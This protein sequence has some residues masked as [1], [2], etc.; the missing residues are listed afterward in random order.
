MEEETKLT[1]TMEAEMVAILSSK[2]FLLISSSSKI[3]LNNS[4]VLKIAIRTVTSQINLIQLLMLMGAPM[5]RRTSVALMLV[6]TKPVLTL[7]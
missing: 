2:G 6:T 4:E 5:T 3:I 7:I 1:I